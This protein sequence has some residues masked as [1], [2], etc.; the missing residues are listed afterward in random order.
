MSA[1]QARRIAANLPGM[2]FQCVLLADG[3]FQF[4]FVSG[5]CQAVYGLAPQEI[6]ADPSLIVSIIHPEDIEAFTASVTETF[7]PT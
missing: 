3:G 6:M 4:P 1:E 5:G 2:V 7:H